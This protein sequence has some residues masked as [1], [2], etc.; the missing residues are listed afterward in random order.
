MPNDNQCNIARKITQSSA[1]DIKINMQYTGVNSSDRFMLSNSIENILKTLH[2]PVEEGWKTLRPEFENIALEYLIN[3][4]TAFCIY[5][6]WKSNRE[7]SKN[8]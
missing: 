6:D 5:E 8:K 1:T 3:P 7:G 4:A 2:M